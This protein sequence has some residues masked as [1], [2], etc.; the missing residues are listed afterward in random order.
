MWSIVGYIW[1]FI[2]GFIGICVA[3][4]IIIT[5]I[6]GA[7]Y[8]LFWTILG[9]C[10]IIYTFLSNIYD[11]FKKLNKRHAKPKTIKR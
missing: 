8:V 1:A 3:A 2:L 5:L 7:G 6:K 10:A 9:L 11:K 4:P